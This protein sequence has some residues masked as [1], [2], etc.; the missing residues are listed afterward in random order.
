MSGK[1]QCTSTALPLSGR[2]GDLEETHFDA[3]IIGSGYGGSIAASRLAATG[4]SVCVLERGREIIPGQ[5][6]TDLEHAREE[7]E[8]VT[9]RAG[10][11]NSQS[12][13]MMQLRLG[14]D[15]HVIVGNG[16]GG[17]SLVNA[18]V[19]IVP[20]M[21]V[22]DSGWPDIYLPDDDPLDCEPVSGDAQKRRPRRRNAL[23][24]YFARVMTNLGAAKLPE[25]RTPPK[26]A[27]LKQSAAAMNQD[28]DR[29]DINVT[30][31]SGPNAF[32]FHQAGCTMCGNCCS[33]CN[34]GAKN[35]LLMNYLPDAHRSGARI[36][37][38]AEVMTVAPDGAGW[39]VSVRDRT[40]SCDDAA[41]RKITGDMVVLAAGTLGS[42]E[43][44]ERSVRAGTGLTLSK[45]LGSK[46]STNGDALGFGFG[47]NLPGSQGKQGKDVRPTPLY[48]I[49][50]GAGAPVTPSGTPYTPCPE[51]PG[52]CIT[53][54]IRVDMDHDS[55][56]D[57]GMLIEDGTAPG[58]FATIYP[59]A[60]FLQDV[61]TANF[62]DFPDAQTRL[63]ALKKLGEGIESGTD[64]AS[65]SY[66]GVM[67][68]LQ[69]YL[70]MSHDESSGNLVFVPGEDGN[71]HVSV[72][73]PDA[74]DTAA[75]RRDDARLKQ[76][77]E[78]IWADYVPN[79]IRAEGFGRNIV[80][81]HPLGGCPMADTEADGVT[82][83][84]CRVYKGDGA[85][86]IY[87]T[88]LVCDGSVVPRCLGVNPL[89]TISAITERAMDRLI[90]AQ[91]PAGAHQPVRLQTP[92][93]T[94]SVAEAGKGWNGISWNIWK[95]SWAASAVAK[96]A[97]GVGTIG[98]G[99]SVLKSE[100]IKLANELS[101]DLDQEALR[102]FVHEF[103]KNADLSDD[104]GP[105]F[106]Q[107]A[108]DLDT[109]SKAISQNSKAPL[110]PF[111]DA[112]FDIAG[113]I[114]PSFRFDETMHGFVSERR[115]PQDHPIS[116]P[117]QIVAGMGRAAGRALRANFRVDANSTMGRD[118]AGNVV[119]D[120]A[121]AAL[122]GEVH[123]TSSDGIKTIY[124]VK[125]GQFDLLQPDPDTVETWLMTYTCILVPQDGD[126]AG[127]LMTGNKY[128]RKQPGS[129][130]W[131]DLTTLFVDLKPLESTTGETPLQGIIT[132]DLQDLAS[133]MAT[134]ETGYVGAVSVKQLKQDLIDASSDGTFC[135]QISEKSKGKGKTKQ[136]LMQKAFLVL[137]N[138]FADKADEWPGE[139]AAGLEKYF[140]AGIV[141]IFGGL[142]L[143]TYGG[144]IAYM[145]DYPSQSDATLDAMP[146]PDDKLCGSVCEDVSLPDADAPRIRL[147]HFAPPDP[148]KELKGPVLLAP[149]M[150]TTA[151]SFALKTTE[152]SLVE[153]LLKENYDVWLFDSRLSPR[154]RVRQDDGTWQVNSDYT[155]DDVAA[156]DWP[157]AVDHVLANT[158]ASGS[159][160][161]SLQIISHCVG[162][163]T[164]Q[165]AL[166]GGHVETSKVRQLVVM[167]FT[168][169]PAA[170]WFNVVKSEIGL[171][172][173]FAGGFPPLIAGVIHAELGDG[174]DWDSVKGVL[175]NGIPVID[176]VSP[177]P[178][179]DDYK[180]PL[181]A[182]H[183]TVDWSAPFGI[184][185]V[186]LSPTCHRIYGLY[187]PVIAHHQV[188]QD[189][190]NAMRQIFGRIATK[191]FEQLGLIMERGQVVSAS[192][193]DV[194][195]P[196]Y[197][198]LRLPVH[199]ISGTVNQIVLPESGYFTQQWL[200]R[201]MPE[202]KHLFTRTLIEGY[203]HNDCII[204][205]NADSDVFDGIME[206]L[207]PLGRP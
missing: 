15:V 80:S 10:R 4:K 125:K 132:L 2:L 160:K 200:K 136:T 194:Y 137:L 19:S 38:E 14:K 171:A 172:K 138:S 169:H 59:P 9:A 165:M 37:T 148:T 6:P 32:G 36:V 3:V 72:D 46:F 53:G 145:Q 153:R 144:F 31:E 140:G 134:V 83:A 55:P 149:G 141:Q 16:L 130:W 112:F 21:R 76:A 54:V 108:E 91:E 193:E 117:Y 27:A 26:L 154:V 156:E 183:N 116:D 79:P 174:A 207:K 143:R 184:D 17:G 146:G 64:P 195:L 42:T 13:G 49:G 77:A 45:K 190:H 29:A 131:T 95:T 63:E 88:L 11:L 168:V 52:P 69:S 89:L 164:A 102:D 39:S 58:P 97:K 206:V 30:F 123:L 75:Y 126:A 35:T 70:V 57:H 78:A 33:G 197:E 121:G 96:T 68:R 100:I 133:Q 94:P 107:L 128:L 8:V 181:D 161:S 158:T 93:P 170:S 20:D 155:L 84:D 113:D 50:A 105:G 25:D 1:A 111:L 34:Y 98:F 180:E 179:S 139:L 150:S 198:R 110:Q 203:A 104:V 186:C 47:A 162:A 135:K 81:V 151:L 74:G 99:T 187:G 188:N 61:L 65:L 24:D 173:G 103:L 44:L 122:T 73:W 152:T 18:G 189:T 114:S 7:V 86:G 199:I 106:D 119:A 67:T 175:D 124:T 185:H 182:I 147:F 142:V 23:T 201:M 66:S 71:G 12:N 43:I 92:D 56:L 196:N 176:P 41:P 40:T 85:N 118:A 177:Q 48:S 192:G 163:L 127:L 87:E 120:V 157:D 101:S 129:F 5:Y 167:Q 191:P 205:K 28:F 115:A 166:L 90:G 22:F 60:L 159:G 204:G 202:S 178:G 62:S 109:L 82:D 51:M